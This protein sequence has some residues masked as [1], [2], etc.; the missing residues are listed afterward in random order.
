VTSKWKDGSWGSIEF[1]SNFNLDLHVASTALHYGQSAFEGLKAFKD[2]N[3]KVRI[4]R[5]QLNA[6]RL[7]RSAQRLLMPIVESKMFI[8]AVT[9]AV[10]KN[11]E[12]V[13]PAESG[14]SLYIRPLLF[15]SGGQ[16]G[17]NVSKEYIFLVYVTPV[18]K[19]YS[20]AIRAWVA[21]NFDRAA[22]KGVGSVKLAGNYAPAIKPHVDAYEKGF[23]IVLYLDSKERKYVEEFETSNFIGITKDGKYITPQSTSILPSITNIS[24]M[25]LAQ[26][27]NISCERR[28]VLWSEVKDLREVGACGTAV[29]I[30]PV[31]FF[32]F[33]NEE[34]DIATNEG[35]SEVLTMLYRDF[36]DIQSGRRSDSFGWLMDV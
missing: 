13:P 24:I 29:G 3:D 2:D 5:P 23:Q 7:Q 35:S 18:G 26:S 31:D 12:F 17:L 21:E 25:E 4:F 20:K 22:P 9:M 36:S 30:T 15:G 10:K 28:P 1:S 33:G 19:Y 27:K 8:K 32:K 11:L 14:G 34:I 6:E 16:L